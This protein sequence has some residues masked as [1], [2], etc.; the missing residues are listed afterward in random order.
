MALI[1]TV[2]NAGYIP[3]VRSSSTWDWLFERGWGFGFWRPLW[4]V[5]DINQSSQSS[6][7]WSPGLQWSLAWVGLGPAR[8]LLLVSSGYTMNPVFH[9]IGASEIPN[10]AGASIKFYRSAAR[11]PQQFE[12]EQWIHGVKELV[13]DNDKEMEVKRLCLHHLRGL[14]QALGCQFDLPTGHLPQ[15][16]RC[17]AEYGVL[18]CHNRT[19][20]GAVR[21]VKGDLTI[22]ARLHFLMPRGDWRCAG[23]MHERSRSRSRS[24]I[25]LHRA[26]RT[27]VLVASAPTA[28]AIVEVYQIH[29]TG[30]A[31]EIYI[32]TCHEYIYI[33]IYNTI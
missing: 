8:G 16:D 17:M 3:G 19:M 9:T 7:T 33:Y 31:A 28:A 5:K 32:Y 10:S 21:V 11:E 14:R 22:Q 20:I 1:C 29:N 4:L 15:P 18:C 6:Q 26:R 2:I 24:G 25:S 27:A 23:V 30:S 12:R 13:A